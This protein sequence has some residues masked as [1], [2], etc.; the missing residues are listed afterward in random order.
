MEAERT[1]LQAQAKSDELQRRVAELEDQLYSTNVENDA[2]KEKFEVVD[3]AVDQ[4][5][6]DFQ[7]MIRARD[8]KIKQYQVFWDRTAEQW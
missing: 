1:S 3:I 2:I 6:A 7:G 8:E 5:S 4:H